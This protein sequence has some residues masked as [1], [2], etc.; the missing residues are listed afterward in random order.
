MVYGL[1]VLFSMTLE[2]SL[3]V[4]YEYVKYHSAVCLY[5]VHVSQVSLIC[6]SDID[7]IGIAVV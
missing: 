3:L 5:N 2:N 7:V 4:S 1:S 6:I